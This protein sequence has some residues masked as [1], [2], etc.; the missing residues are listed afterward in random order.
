M[1]ASAGKVAPALLKAVSLGL[2]AQ[3]QV[4]LHGQQQ[5]RLAVPEIR[6]DQINAY[7][8]NDAGRQQVDEDAKKPKTI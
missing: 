7:A 6:A 5:A 3:E 4:L 8:G 1:T 2:P